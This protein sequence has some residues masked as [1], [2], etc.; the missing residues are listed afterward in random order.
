MGY[1]P[2][3]SLV[4]DLYESDI[5]SMDCKVFPGNQV[6]IQPTKI[7]CSSF[8]SSIATSNTIKF[9]FWVVN[10]SSTKGMGIPI[11]VYAYDQPSARKFV[12]SII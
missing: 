1:K 12:W 7:V 10:P 2:Y 9:G 8:S 11:Q 5:S 4:F 6:D 3:D